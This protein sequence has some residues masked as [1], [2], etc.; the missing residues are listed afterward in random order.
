[1]IERQGN[2]C[3]LQGDVTIDT[4]PDLAENI[5]PLVREG[6]DTLDCSGIGNVDSAVLGLLIAAKREAAAGRR[7]L[8]ITGLSERI[9][10]LASLYGVADLL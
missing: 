4:V 1:M 3:R 5:R 2:V 7:S 8:K 6:V 10:N 9:H